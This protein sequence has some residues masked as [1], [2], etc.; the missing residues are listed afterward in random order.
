MLIS[1]MA[2]MKPDLFLSRFKSTDV[3]RNIIKAGKNNWLRQ[4][5][6]TTQHALSILL[7]IATVIV[8]KQIHYLASKDIGFDKDQIAVIQLA[9]TNIDLNHKSPAF[10][11]ALKQSPGVIAVSASNRVPGQSFNGYGIIPEAHTL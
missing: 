8:N 5:M 11:T 3:F 4:S 6:I 1:L 9:N 10:I 2:R 7:I